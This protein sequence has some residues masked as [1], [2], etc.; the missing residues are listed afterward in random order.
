[1][2]AQTYGRRLTLLWWIGAFPVVLVLLVRLMVEDDSVPA[3]VAWLSTY[4]LPGLTLV[5]GVALTRAA[6]DPGEPA[7]D[8]GSVFVA[9]ALSSSLYLLILILA[10]LKVVLTTGDTAENLLKPWGAVLGLFQ[11]IVIGLLGRFFAKS[12]A[13]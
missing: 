3:I 12:P 8:L 13:R 9:A 11:A 1:M 6:A 10:V 4:L 2:T 5:S 7:P